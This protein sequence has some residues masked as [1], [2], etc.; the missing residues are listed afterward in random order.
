MIVPLISFISNLGLERER[1]EK[2]VRKILLLYCHLASL[3]FIV[4]VAHVFWF[5]ISLSFY[6]GIWEDPKTILPLS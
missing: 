4:N 1:F 6:V 5:S 3:S 2:D